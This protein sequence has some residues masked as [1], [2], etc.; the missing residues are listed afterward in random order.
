MLEDAKALA[1]PIVARG[2]ED[3]E[4]LVEEARG[5]HEEIKSAFESGFKIEATHTMTLGKVA[6]LV[7][8]LVKEKTE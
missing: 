1:M 3:S 2:S 5:V 4:A 6:Y 8:S 7:Y